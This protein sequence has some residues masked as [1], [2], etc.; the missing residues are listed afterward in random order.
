MKFSYND[1]F[2]VSHWTYWVGFYDFVLNELFPQK[3]ETYKIFNAE[4][5][6]FYKNTH[7]IIPFD[8]ICFISE[9][10]TVIKTKQTQN[11][12]IMHNESGPSIKYKDDYAIYALNGV[13][14]PEW[15]LNQPKEELK[16]QDIIKIDNAEQR[17]QAM[18]HKG[19][20]H[21]FDQ[22]KV[23]IIDKKD[24]Y[25]LLLVDHAGEMC[26]YLKMIN[27]STGEIHLEGIM[28]NI[29]TVNDAL[30]WRNGLEYWIN[31]TALT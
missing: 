9:R 29:K 7:I 27:P 22:L 23:S 20:G 8:N 30:A 18:K 16:S 13:V 5:I 14:M 31:P 24:N 6:E 1:S 2:Y 17:M 10:P 19:M 26:E 21:F 3:K 15:V 12:I 25:E 28:P 4:C 11:G